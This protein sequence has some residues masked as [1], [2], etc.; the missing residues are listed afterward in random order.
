MLSNRWLR[1]A[2]SSTRGNTV[3]FSRSSAG[4]YIRNDKIGD[5]TAIQ[6][7]KGAVVIE[8]DYFQPGDAGESDL[9]RQG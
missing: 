5:R 7:E 3:V 9:V 4:S 1:S 6:E 2:R 8:V